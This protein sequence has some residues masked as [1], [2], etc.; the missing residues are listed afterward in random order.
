MHIRWRGL[1]TSYGK[2]VIIWVSHAHLLTSHEC[3]HVGNDYCV[4]VTGYKY[5]V[6]IAMNPSCLL[7]VELWALAQKCQVGR[8]IQSKGQSVSESSVVLPCLITVQGRSFNK[9][10][11]NCVG[12]TVH[13]MRCIS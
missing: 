2:E 5:Y 3:E 13:K 9:L 6:D 1:Q 11:K 10:K 7:V 8:S 12:A 4:T